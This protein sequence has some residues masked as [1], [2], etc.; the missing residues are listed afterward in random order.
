MN[1]KLEDENFSE[2]KTIDLSN[3]I[4]TDINITALS[5]VNTIAEYNET[6]DVLTFNGRIASVD[7]DGFLVVDANAEYDEEN[8]ILTLS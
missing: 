6:E 3:I 1:E 7:E 8:E 2:T 5:K 4:Y